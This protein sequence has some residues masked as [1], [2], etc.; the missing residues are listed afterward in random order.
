MNIR[1][2][3]VTG[4]LLVAA[5]AAG[6]DEGWGEPVAGISVGLEAARETWTEGEPIAFTVR[7]RNGTKDP[8][9]LYDL[10]HTWFLHV[11]FET[12]DGAESFLGGSRLNR[13]YS[14][15]ADVTLAA[16]ETW[17][18]KIVLHDDGH[19]FLRIIPDRRPGDDWDYRKVLPP[20]RY[21]ARISYERGADSGKFWTGR[22]V[23][24]AVAIAVESKNRAPVVHGKADIETL[25]ADVKTVRGTNLDDA[26]LA[27]LSSRT[28]LEELDLSFNPRLSAEGLASL[29]TLT[30]AR[31][32]DLSYCPGFK[33]GSLKSLALL[34]A[35]Q[36]LRLVNSGLDDRS[37]AGLKDC[38]SLTTIVLGAVE[39][40]YD[41]DTANHIGDAGLACLAQIPTL[42]RLLLRWHDFTS[43]GI[44]SLSTHPNLQELDLFGGDVTDEALE[45]LSRLDLTVLDCGDSS[46]LHDAGLKHLFRMQGLRTLGLSE[47]PEITDEGVASLAVLKGLKS[48]DLRKCRKVTDAG[49]AKL[50]ETLPGCEVRR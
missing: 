1:T 33:G 28:S 23:S 12:A 16:E 37:L 8:L 45:A 38:P 13:D 42:K 2:F 11:T 41:W 22:A 29:K 47:C 43:E 20:G 27:A 39:Y 50:R 31:I 30:R 17:T 15:S 14:S 26:A 7:V 5:A 34:P 4:L 10:G 9:N 36:E 35:L 24:R 21:K 32:L 46:K 44:K 40:E 25:P 48:L 19:E 6:A 49:V 3:A 18:K